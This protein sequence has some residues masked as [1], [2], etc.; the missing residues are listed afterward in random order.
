VT[1]A[2][3][4]EVVTRGEAIVADLKQAIAKT[5]DLTSTDLEVCL[6]KQLENSLRIHEVMLLHLRAFAPASGSGYI[7]IRLTF[8]NRIRLIFGQSIFVVF[9]GAV[10]MRHSAYVA[11]SSW[12]P[13]AEHRA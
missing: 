6:L 2:Q 9:A 11:R 4:Q 12:K 8:G 5:S 3:L 10:R 7:R 1:Q 13:L